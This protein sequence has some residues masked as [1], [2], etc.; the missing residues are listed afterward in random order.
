MKNSANGTTRIWLNDAHGFAARRA[1][2][3]YRAER[4]RKAAREGKRPARVTKAQVEEPITVKQLCGAIGVPFQQIFPVLKRDHDLL[5]GI[6][7]IIDKEIAELLAT[8]F[9]VELTVVE[10]KTGL[11]KLK[12]EHEA[13]PRT[14]MA[15]RPPI[16]T[17]LGHVDHGKT[18]LLDRIRKAN[19]ASGEDG[20]ITQHISSYHI[21]NDNIAVTFLDTRVMKRSPPSGQEGPI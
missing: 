9:G 10:A 6:T 3:W 16:V 18:S 19:I 2:E 17:V 20:G 14:N 4:H 13:L 15:I 8:E 1:D 5:V 12:E 7:S 21:K 11:E